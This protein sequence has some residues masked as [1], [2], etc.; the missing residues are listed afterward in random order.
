MHAVDEVHVSVA[1]GPKSTELRAVRPA[2]ECAAGSPR[3]SLARDES[4][5]IKNLLL[6]IHHLKE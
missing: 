2:A 6:S 4:L 5:H 3:R 1:G